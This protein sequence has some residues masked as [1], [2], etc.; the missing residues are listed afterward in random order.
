MSEAPQFEISF[1]T[2]RTFHGTLQT[3]ATEKQSFQSFNMVNSQRDVK[4]WDDNS[5]I[6]MCAP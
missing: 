3:E 5:F 6:D 4:K 2:V 1:C